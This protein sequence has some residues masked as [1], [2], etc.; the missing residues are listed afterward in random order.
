MEANRERRRVC[1][2]IQRVQINNLCV[3][4]PLYNL[5]C[6]LWIPQQISQWQSPWLLEIIKNSSPFREFNHRRS[7]QY[8]LLLTFRLNTNKTPKFYKQRYKSKFNS[9]NKGNLSKRRI[10]ETLYCVTDIFCKPFFLHGHT[11]LVLWSLENVIFRLFWKKEDSFIKRINQQKRKKPI[12]STSNLN[13]LLE[14]FRDSQ[15]RHSSYWFSFNKVSNH[16]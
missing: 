6:H 7:C 13:S 3:I 14:F 15:Y 8:G 11:I 1:L 5:F 10:S 2:F 16:R 4:F 9:G 12:R